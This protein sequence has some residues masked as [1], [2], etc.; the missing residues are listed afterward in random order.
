MAFYIGID[1]GGTGSRL[2][3][4][5]PEGEV[6]F[7]AE[8]GSTNLAS[9]E[10]HIV[11]M[12]ITELAMTLKPQDCLGVCI[13]SAGASTAENTALL[14]KIFLDMG[15]KH[16]PVRIMNDAELVLHGETREAPG[17]ILIAGTGSVGYAVSPQREVIRVGGWGHLIDDGGSGYRMAMDGIKAAMGSFDGTGA[18]TTL[19]ATVAEFF[20][21]TDLSQITA[22]IYGEN[23][24]KGAI[25]KL[26][27]KVSQAASAGD[28]VGIKIQNDA[29]DALISIAKA[30]ITRAGLVN[31]KLI[32]SGS[33]LK[34]NAYIAKVFNEAIL[35][36]YP[37]MQIGHSTVTPEVAGAW[38]AKDFAQGIF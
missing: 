13:G 27:V 17:A 24:N 5:T 7:T 23:F 26:A 38:L 30:L 37:E 10:Y 6:F 12:N 14:K 32:V 15:Y 22:H 18:K 3:A 29:A 2:A 33:L 35:G 9:N 1:G 36:A 11:A 21:L 4:M 31:H 19:E 20:N 34:K 25:A 28:A 8:S 16:C